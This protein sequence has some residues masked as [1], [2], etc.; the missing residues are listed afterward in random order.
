MLMT[1]LTITMLCGNCPV[2]GEGTI[3]DKPFYFRARGQGWCMAIGGDIFS[4]PEW[5]RLRPYG[6]TKYAAGWMPEEEAQAFIEQ[7]AEDF[8][9]GI[10]GGNE[11]HDV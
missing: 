7:S 8:L 10:P 6:E 3:G 11:H 2:Q 9:K 4:N 5:V 1:K